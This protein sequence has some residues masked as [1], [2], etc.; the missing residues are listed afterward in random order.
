[1]STRQGYVYVGRPSA[2]E[3]SDIKVYLNKTHAE[4][5]AARQ[6]VSY[7]I[8]PYDC[9]VSD[10]GIWAFGICEGPPLRLVQMVDSIHEAEDMLRWRPGM[11]ECYTVSWRVA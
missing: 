1:M 4:E 11:E 8:I 3:D 5:Y 10:D 6:G 9:K 2:D 7:R